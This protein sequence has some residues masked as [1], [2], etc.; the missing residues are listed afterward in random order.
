MGGAL[1]DAI[2][3]KKKHA[4]QGVD[5]DALVLWNVSIPADES[6]EEKLEKLNLADKHPL[7]PLVELSSLFADQPVGGH[8]NIVAGS[9]YW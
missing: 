7:R 4:F 9:S 8:L 3:E 1:K 6:L 2:K 5:A